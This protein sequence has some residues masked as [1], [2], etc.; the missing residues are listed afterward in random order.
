MNPRS[1][2]LGIVRLVGRVVRN[3]ASSSWREGSGKGENRLKNDLDHGALE[4]G[5]EGWGVDVGKIVGCTQSHSPRLCS[6]RL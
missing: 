3:G 2:S 5:A 6:L 4:M 1:K